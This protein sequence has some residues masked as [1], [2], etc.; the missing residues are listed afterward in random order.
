MGV[1]DMT[2]EQAAPEQGQSDATYLGVGLYATFRIDGIELLGEHGSPLVALSPTAFVRLMRFAR[3]HMG[4]EVFKEIDRMAG[5]G[6]HTTKGAQSPVS[7][8]RSS[9]VGSPTTGEKVQQG[10]PERC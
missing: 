5:G 4:Q 7:D 10:R 2:N 8:D 6:R 3:K 9:D 1:R